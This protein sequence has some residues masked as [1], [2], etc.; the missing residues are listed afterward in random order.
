VLIAMIA[1]RMADDELV[2]PLDKPAEVERTTA[3]ED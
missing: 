2:H 3:A 1:A